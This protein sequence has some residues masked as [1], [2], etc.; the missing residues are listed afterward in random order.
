MEWL[1]FAIDYGIIGLLVLMSV[2]SVTIA[3]SGG[4]RTD[5]IRPAGFASKKELELLLT[6]RI[7]VIATVGSNAPCTW[8]F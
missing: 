3:I 7:D 8:A 2:V 5:G 1:K 6:S 4:L